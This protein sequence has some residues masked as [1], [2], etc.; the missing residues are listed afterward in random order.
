VHAK[1]RVTDHGPHSIRPASI[2]IPPG[3]PKCAVCRRQSHW[4]DPFDRFRCHPG[5]R[6]ARS[7]IGASPKKYVF[8]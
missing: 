3:P 1:A 2:A 7:R 5:G 6:W 8:R 4:F